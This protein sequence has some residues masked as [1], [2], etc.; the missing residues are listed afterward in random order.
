MT[1]TGDSSCTFTSRI[2]PFIDVIVGV[3]Q[4]KHHND[5]WRVQHLRNQ[6]RGD[7]ANVKNQLRYATLEQTVGKKEI[8]L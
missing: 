2:N 4:S 8:R 3:L 5:D 6:F 7:E 1:L